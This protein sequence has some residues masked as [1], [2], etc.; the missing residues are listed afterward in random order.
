MH[1]PSSE[2]S[3]EEEMSTRDPYL[4]LNDNDEF[5]IEQVEEKK[6]VGGTSSTREKTKGIS[7]C[8]IRISRCQCISCA[9][10]SSSVCCES[11]GRGS[12]NV[13]FD[14]HEVSPCS[15]KVLLQSNFFL[16]GIIIH[17]KEL[18]CRI[19]ISHLCKMLHTSNTI[20]LFSSAVL[21]LTRLYGVRG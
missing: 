17:W 4:F 8:Q 16:S 20:V 18:S 1:I 2:R 11:A 13:R 14:D 19:P 12:G 9:I 5:G 7:W 6:R 10:C 15:K 21:N 3:E